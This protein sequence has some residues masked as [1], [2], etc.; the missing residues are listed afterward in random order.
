VIKSSNIIQFVNEQSDISEINVI[1]SKNLKFDKVL[2]VNND[3]EATKGQLAWISKKH[4]KNEIKKVTDFNGSILIIPNKVF[5][6]L[7]QLKIRFTLIETSDPKLLFIRIA[8]HFFK[9]LSKNE[10]PDSN[11][12]FIHKGAKIGNKVN[13]APG[14]TIGSNVEINDNV[15]IGP[16]TVIDNTKIESN[17]SIG[18]NNSIGLMGFGYEKN[19][20]NIYESFPHFGKVIINENVEIGS[21]NCIDRGSLKNTVI[22][23]GSKID[24]LVHIAHNVKIGKNC[25]LIG[26]SQIAGSVQLG[27]NVWVAPSASILNGI[28]VGNNTFI[29]IGSVVI[30][31]I[32]N[33]ISVFGNPARALKK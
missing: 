27:D 19:D 9:H 25:M 20:K 23:K 10:W 26:Q 3:Y 4:I 33:D 8:N 7:D 32:Q 5:N 11:N 22:G 14:V 15:T 31:D 29:G 24:N 16:N 2:G 1:D 17:V 21:N 13:I 6:N 18:S 12:F 28:K 30:K